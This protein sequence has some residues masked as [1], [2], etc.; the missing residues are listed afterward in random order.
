MAA[1]WWSQASGCW[2]Q[3]IA[4]DSELKRQRRTSRAHRGSGHA[5]RLGVRYRGVRR[6]SW[7]CR[8]GVPLARDRDS[9]AFIGNDSVACASAARS[10]QGSAISR[11]RSSRRSREL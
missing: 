2:F 1:F 4:A 5:C 9:R 6:Q 8:R 3:L 10:D 7:Q 11:A